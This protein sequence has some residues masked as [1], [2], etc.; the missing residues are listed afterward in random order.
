MSGHKLYLLL[1]KRA[2]ALRR[3]VVVALCSFML[4]VSACSGGEKTSTNVKDN[5]A[6]KTQ[7]STQRFLSRATFGATQTELNALTGTD[8]SDWMVGE[9]EKT[10][11][12]ILPALEAEYKKLPK[13][14]YNLIRRRT[15]DMFIEN[16]ILAD[17]QLRQRMVLALS[18]IIVVSNQGSLTRNTLA[19]GYYVDTLSGHAFGNYRDLLEDL[20]YSPAM[21][22]WLTYMHSEKGDPETGRV[23]DENYAREILQLFSIGL[24]ELNMDGTLKLDENGN[25]IETYTNEDIVGL[26]KVFTGMSF[27]MLRFK[28]PMRKDY[29]ASFRPMVVFPEHHSKL[30]KRFLGVTIP[31]ET[32]GEESIE[33]ALDTIFS[34]PNV[35]PFLSKQLIQRFVT[36]NP[37][38]KYVERVALAFENGT[39]I[40]PDGRKLGTGVRG[41]LK[42]TVAAVL[43]DKNALQSPDMVTERFGKV[44]EPLLRFIHWA[45]TFSDGDPD[46]S[47]EMLLKINPSNTKI[48]QQAFNSK[49]VFNFFSPSFVKP[50]TLTGEMGLSAPELQIVN[51]VTVVQYIN[52]INAFIYNRAPQILQISDID[53]QNNTGIN[54]DYSEQIALADNADALVDSLDVLLTGKQLDAGTRAN[55]VA[56]MHELPIRGDSSGEDKLLRVRAAISMIMTDPSY[57]VQK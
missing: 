42:A 1:T 51:E 16:A 23:P 49:T 33:I 25:P 29:T 47:A 50:N 27:D 44:R 30:E 34:H 6:F 40:L 48:G 22:I 21:G 18:E 31:E 7:A 39:Y 41:D 4:I 24:N 17:D 13:G 26:A 52:F 35:A 54:A 9:F 36:S 45:R 8:I 43:L 56:L 28:Q 14:K 53:A 32:S 5:V 10:P 11:T 46:A 3:Y 37:T 55:I 15:S 12:L 19:M 38:P 2:G 57:I 20:T